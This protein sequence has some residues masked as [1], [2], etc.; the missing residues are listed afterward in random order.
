MAVTKAVAS[1]A[2]AVIASSNGNYCA[3]VAAYA[4]AAGIRCMVLTLSRYGTAVAQSSD[5][6]IVRM[7]LSDGIYA[8]THRR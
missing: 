2:S 7:Q 6:A 5:D 4:A 1:G 8:N 3:A